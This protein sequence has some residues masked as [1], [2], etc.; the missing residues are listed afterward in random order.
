MWL[1]SL[2]GY[3]RNYS[4]IPYAANFNSIFNTS[5]ILQNGFT[6]ISVNSGAVTESGNGEGAGK[7]KNNY[8]FPRLSQDPCKYLSKC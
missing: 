7:R 3:F 5:R 6:Q 2:Y 1:Y 8:D 4:L